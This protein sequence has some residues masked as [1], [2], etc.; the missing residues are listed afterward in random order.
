MELNGFTPTEEYHPTTKK[1]VDEAF[2]KVSTAGAFL[3]LENS[4]DTIITTVG[5]YEK[6]TGT[7]TV[8]GSAGTVDTGTT[9]RIIYTGIADRK[10][11]IDIVAQVSAAAA[12][13]EISIVVAKSG[14]EILKTEM[15]V[16]CVTSGNPYILPVHS[17]EKLQQNEYLEVFIT[18]KT[19]TATVT[20]EKLHFRVN[21]Q[22]IYS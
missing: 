3:W 14:V 7:T 12:D 13:Q 21:S 10:F 11:N 17:I 9:N 22:Y 16:Q 15:S 8:A 19:S 1:Y 2:E 20:L 5:E 6:A 18:N 4:A